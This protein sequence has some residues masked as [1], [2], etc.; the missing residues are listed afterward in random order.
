[1]TTMLSPLCNYISLVA[2]YMDA[3]CRAAGMAPI[4]RKP[5]R[6]QFCQTADKI[7]KDLS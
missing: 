7:L 4:C 5:T 3:T 6:C 2:S 1:M